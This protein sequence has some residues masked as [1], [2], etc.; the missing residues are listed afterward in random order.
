[1]RWCDARL[2][3]SVAVTDRF[4][5]SPETFKSC[6]SSGERRSELA[7]QIA[8]IVDEVVGNRAADCVPSRSVQ[9]L[10]EVRGVAR[11][12]SLAS[13]VANPHH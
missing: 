9:A 13:H 4:D 7:Q 3:P 10:K 5:G 1:M 2:W 12:F 8:E 11:G 6:T